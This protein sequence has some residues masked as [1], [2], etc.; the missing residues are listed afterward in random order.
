MHTQVIYAP[1]F[2]KPSGKLYLADAQNN[3]VSGIQIL[4][5]L[6]T[7]PPAY[8]DGIENVVTHRITPGRA[9]FY[10]IVGQVYFM[11]VIT[12]KGYHSYLRIS[13]GAY[14]AECEVHAALVENISALCSLPC[15]YLSAADYIE[16]YAMSEAGVNTVDVYP[17]EDRTYLSV[18]RVR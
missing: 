6:D 3:L 14:V 5:L 4:I 13:G 15:H 2:Q 16:L 11:N 12:D 10:A 9:G 18:Q 8:K 1:A 17:S 7:I